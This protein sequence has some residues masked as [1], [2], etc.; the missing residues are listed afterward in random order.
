MPL[1]ML[2][3][4]LP[5]WIQFNAQY[6][7]RV[8]ES[9]HIGFHPGSD[10]YDLSE[11]RA[12]LALRPTRW[13]RLVGEMQDAAVFFNERIPSAPTY[14]NRWDIRQAFAEI[15][16]DREGWFDVIGGR[17]MLSF[18]EERLIGPSDWAN[19]GRTFDV[20]R[21]DLHRPGFRTSIFAS[22]VVIAR[23]G[24]IDHHLQGNNFYGV[25][26]T[27]EKLIPKSVVEPFVLWRVAP[28]NVKLNENQGHGALNEVTTGARVAGTFHA[29]DYSVEMA[30]QRGSLGP[31][32]IEAW[33][34]HWLVGRTFGSSG[35]PR[36]FLESNHASGTPSQTGKTWG[37]FDQIYP[38]SHN[39][40]DFADQV[41]WRNVMQV[42]TGVDEKIRK[43]SLS[44]NYES[45]WRSSTAD[46]FYNSGGALVVAA[47]AGQGRFV[48][49]EVDLLSTYQVNKA[50]DFGIGYCHFFTGRF[51]N[52]SGRTSDYNYPFAYID[53]YLTNAREH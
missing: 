20:I 21:A 36:V 10:T 29:W 8:E 42:R 23:D 33:A 43:L 12:E 9:G 13:L 52:T 32:S 48:G 7:N 49:Q 53:F 1:Q 50:M 16:D 35:K 24:V 18:G 5:R 39:K 19:Q 14:Q 26:N 4:R 38:S 6:R 25:Y 46:G 3:E 17:E 41:G 27:F 37:T 28:G 2:D 11:L 34:G 51:L 31:Y 22:S 45:F 30:I 40:L 44:Q 15:G 47:S